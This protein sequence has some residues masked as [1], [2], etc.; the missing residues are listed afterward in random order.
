VVRLAERLGVMKRLR[1]VT[2]KRRCRGIPVEDFVMSLASSFLVG[3]DSLSD[4]SVLREEAVTRAL[5]FGLEVPA[6]T[7]AGATVGHAA[8]QK[9]VRA[10]GRRLADDR[11]PHPAVA[12]CLHAPP[13]GPPTTPRNPGAARRSDETA[14]TRGS[15]LS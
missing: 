1:G 11:T 6:P 7:T 14:F 9:R 13:I 8:R 10:T 4:L 5:C 15:G 2:V 12:E 3:G